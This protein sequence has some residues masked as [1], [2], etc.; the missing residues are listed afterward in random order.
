MSISTENLF[1]KFDGIVNDN[2]GW[3]RTNIHVKTFLLLTFAAYPI[4]ARP[5]LPNFI[6]KLFSNI[7][8][9]FLLIAYIVYN[10]EVVKD[11]QLAII[12]T[13]VFLSIMHF[14]NKKSLEKEL[15]QKK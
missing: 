4:L 12:V 6:E 2:L 9:R 15:E 1:Q 13:V 10:I 11:K 14:V 8:V 3:I 7:L 5:K